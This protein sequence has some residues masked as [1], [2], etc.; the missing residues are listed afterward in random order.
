MFWSAGYL[1]DIQLFVYIFWQLFVDKSSFEQCFLND[2]LD[3]QVTF[4][5]VCIT[6]WI[7]KTR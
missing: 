2:F 5:T 6:S 1:P 3:K 4:A 7:Q